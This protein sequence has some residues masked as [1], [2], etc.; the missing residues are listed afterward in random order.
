[1][2]ANGNATDMKAMFDGLIADL[3]KQFDT[4]KE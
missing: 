3:H 1:M 2:G 4:M